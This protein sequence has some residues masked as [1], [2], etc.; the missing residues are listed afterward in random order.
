MTDRPRTW[1]LEGW[2]YRTLSG[3]RPSQRITNGEQLVPGELVRVVEDLGW[4]AMLAWA[5]RNAGREA[6]EALIAQALVR[7]AIERDDD[8]TLPQDWTI[9]ARTAFDLLAGTDD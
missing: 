5:V 4:E 6:V 1:T 7:S 8:R 9:E 2:N 3:P